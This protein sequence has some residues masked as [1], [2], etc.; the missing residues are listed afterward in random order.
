MTVFSGRTDTPE[1]SF[2]LTDR[3]TRTTTVTLAA[4]VRR[5]LIRSGPEAWGETSQPE[6]LGEV[7]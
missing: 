6:I 7:Y 3:H 5:G 4:H 2:D 1:V